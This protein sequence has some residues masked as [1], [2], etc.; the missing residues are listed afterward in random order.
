MPNL[1]RRNRHMLLIQIQYHDITVTLADSASALAL[2]PWRPPRSHS[3]MRP[4]ALQPGT[5]IAQ[6]IAPIEHSCFLSELRRPPDG[7]RI[8]LLLPPPP[9]RAAA[10]LRR[11]RRPAAATA[12]PQPSGGFAVPTKAA[13]NYCAATP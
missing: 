1:S 9:R 3:P 7:P 4:S 13:V 2:W 8:A 5:R 12:G 6:S 11:A 10:A